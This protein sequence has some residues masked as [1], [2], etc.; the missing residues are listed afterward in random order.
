MNCL[1]Y[2]FHY[3]LL[4]K[5]SKI[6]IECHFIKAVKSDK[7]SFRLYYR[8]LKFLGKK[9][10]LLSLFVPH[11]YILHEGIKKEYFESR[12]QFEQTKKYKKLM[13][14]YGID[15][16]SPMELE[17]LKFIPVMLHSIVTENGFHILY[18]FVDS[19]INGNSTIVKYE[20]FSED[21]GIQELFFEINKKPNLW[22]A[23]TGFLFI[24]EYI[25]E[26][27]IIYHGNEYFYKDEKDYEKVM[28]SFNMLEE[29]QFDLFVFE[30]VGVNYNSPDFPNSMYQKYID[31]HTYSAEE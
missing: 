21:K 30:N 9:D 10:T 26:E 19:I 17:D 15:I 5:H 24:D 12:I 29:T 18:H 4:N 23:P 28:N 1:T 31:E 14:K 2:A 13:A 6:K 27:H 8:Y 20:V 7:F 11:F 16:E 22:I 25:I 3:R